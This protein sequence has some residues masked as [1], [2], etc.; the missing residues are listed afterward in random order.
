M[1]K[2]FV[3]LSVIALVSLLLTKTV[4]AEKNAAQNTQNDC[5]VIIVNGNDNTV[6]FTVSPQSSAETTSCS[7]ESHATDEN[8]FSE[9]IDIVKI[10]IPIPIAELIKFI[11]K[12][13]TN[14]KDTDHDKQ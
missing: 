1:K 2:W 5:P 7:N 12:K 9:F 6:H 10:S 4:R 11:H 13:L 3:L 14:K 8:P